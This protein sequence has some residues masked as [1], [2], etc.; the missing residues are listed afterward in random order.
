MLSHSRRVLLFDKI[1][2]SNTGLK[3]APLPHQAH[4]IPVAW[5]QARAPVCNE[6]T[7]RE[8]RLNVILTLRGCLLDDLRP[9]ASPS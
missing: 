9:S 7:R 2:Y 1:P 8:V 6:L 5:P 4:Y 3:S